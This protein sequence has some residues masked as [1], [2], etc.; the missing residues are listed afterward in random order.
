MSRVALSEAPSLSKVVEGGEYKYG[1]FSEG[2]EKY[3]LFTYGKVVGITRETIINDDLDAFSRIPT[4][5]GGAAARLEANTVY[6]VFTANAAMSDTVALFHASHGNLTNALLNVAGIG[7][8][9]NLMRLQ[10]WLGGNDPMN[11]NPRYLIVPSALE[12]AASQLK[13]Q[14]TPAQASNA[15]PLSNTFDIIVE[16]R[17]DGNSA[18]NYYM[19][20][21]PSE[22][23][24]IEYAYLE[25]EDGPYIE[26]REGFGRDGIEIKIRHDFAAKAIDYRGLIKSTNNGS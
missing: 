1:T 14:L 19:A 12:V 10:T 21:D 26:T 5:F 8:C 6:G 24:T 25:G 20:A 23:D 22:I 18:L 16:A 13:A 17:L 3:R 11:I 9:R 4:L 7:T 15:N 2:S